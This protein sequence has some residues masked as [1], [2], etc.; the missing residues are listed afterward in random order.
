[1]RRNT[2]SIFWIFGLVAAPACL[3]QHT[4][5]LD[6]KPSHTAKSD[7]FLSGAPFT[8][9]QTLALLKQDA[10]PL[11]R[12]KEAIQNRGVDFMLSADNVAKIN[13]TAASPE[14]IDLIHSKAKP[15]PPPPPPKPAP[16]G[17][18]RVQCAPSE[19][20]VALNGKPLGET[21][22]GALELASLPPGKWIIDLSKSGYISKQS[23]ALVEDNKTTD[24]SAVLDPDR[25]TEE[26][27]GAELLHKI[28]GALG[29]DEG[30]QDLSSVDAIGSATIVTRDGADIRWS[31][32]MRHH[33]SRSLFQAKAGRV[34]HAVMFNGHEFTASKSLKG[35]DALELP[36][37][38]G[39]IRD[40]QLAVLL[41]RLQQPRYKLLARQTEPKAGEE[42]V[43]F[44]EGGTDKISIGLN[45]DLRPQRVHIQT[46]TGIGSLLITYSD[47][48][49]SGRAWYPK[50]MQAKPDGQPNGIQVRFDTVELSPKF[51]DSDLRLKGGIF[52]NFYN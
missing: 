45:G 18:I 47:Y 50:N 48:V 13:A 5:A 44:A 29:G 12:R 37:D 1:M 51:K 3:A 30:I 21:L 15:V 49:Q 14:L 39:Y 31:L 46:E 17:S 41:A 9:E 16:K 23:A 38:F 36:A 27:F 33:G 22:G 34:T 26:A 10:I 25:A 8:L 43:L 7:P 20:N 28:I 19:C 42:Y 32:R 40:H 6:R 35:Q 24:V 11:R 4:A 2:L 52:S